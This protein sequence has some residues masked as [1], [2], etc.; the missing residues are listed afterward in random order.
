VGKTPLGVTVTA[1]L[2]MLGGGGTFLFAMMWAAL[3]GMGHAGLYVG[4][5][6]SYWLVLIGSLLLSAVSFVASIGILQKAS[7]ARY[8]SIAV[9]VFSAVQ[10][11][12]AASLLFCCESLDALVTL[13]IVVNAIFI[14]YFQSR[15]VKDYFLKHPSAR[16]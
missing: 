15:Q 12:Y 5:P 4:P 1:V 16:N 7:Y 9:W 3:G 10:Y 13:A 11:C 2:T 8:L 6:I 14:I